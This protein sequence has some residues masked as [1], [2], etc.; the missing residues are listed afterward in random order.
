MK[1]TENYS[2][3]HPNGRCCG[4]HGGPK[5]CFAASGFQNKATQNINSQQP[6][7]T[8]KTKTIPALDEN[9][10]KLKIAYETIDN[11]DHNKFLE[12]AKKAFEI[13]NAIL[14]KLNI[15]PLE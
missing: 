4:G 2:F 6:D 9:L 3:Q 8:T 15:Q 10:S 7:R 11:F 5:N 1:P 13:I 14:S 12:G